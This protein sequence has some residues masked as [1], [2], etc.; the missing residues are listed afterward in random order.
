VCGVVVEEASHEV[1]V[2]GSNQGSRGASR[3]AGDGRVAGWW[4]SAP[5][6]IFFY[7]F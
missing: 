4:G 5:K 2:T 3:L 1:E 7:L 6:Q